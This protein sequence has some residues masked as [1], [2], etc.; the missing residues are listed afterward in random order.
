M[1]EDFM[2][3]RGRVRWGRVWKYLHGQVVFVGGLRAKER[4][5]KAGRGTRRGGID[6]VGGPQ[7]AAEGK[8]EKEH[9]L[10]WGLVSHPH[11]AKPGTA[12]GLIRQIA[13]PSTK[14]H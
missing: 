6:G 3:G 12:L 13:T 5:G 2:S 10:V 14:L 11:P 1:R 7:W 4:A 8:Q 9:A